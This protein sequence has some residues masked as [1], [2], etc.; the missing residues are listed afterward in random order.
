M[1]ARAPGPARRRIRSSSPPVSS[2]EASS[3]QAAVWAS[4][5]CQRLENC[6]S[7]E[8]LHRPTDSQPGAKFC[9]LA[10][11]WR[12]LTARALPFAL[13]CCCQGVPAAEWAYGAVYRLKS[14]VCVYA[15]DASLLARASAFGLPPQR[16]L[17][18]ASDDIFL[19]DGRL[20]RSLFSCSTQHT[21]PVG[22]V[23]RRVLLGC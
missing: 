18:F 22:E 4:A 12:D 7:P 15:I 1:R 6:G 11:I 16:G 9:L 20:A 3:A 21:A 5:G 14:C 23:G 8:L 2:R 19:L 10:K 17:C 13:V